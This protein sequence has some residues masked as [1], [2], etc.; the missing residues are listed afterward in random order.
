MFLSKLVQEQEAVSQVLEEET[1]LFVSLLLSMTL[2]FC[3][4]SFP[5]LRQTIQFSSNK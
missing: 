5:F 2:I 3:L 4:T 1:R